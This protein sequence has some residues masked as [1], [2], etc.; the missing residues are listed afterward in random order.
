MPSFIKAGHTNARHGLASMSLPSRTW[1]SIS[2]SLASLEDVDVEDVKEGVHQRISPA[3]EETLQEIFH[4]I[5]RD[6]NG[7]LE[8]VELKV[9]N[10]LALSG[11]TQAV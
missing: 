8:V 9:C 2:S 1:G 7:K 5:D 3:T 4:D 11:V 6:H 10:P